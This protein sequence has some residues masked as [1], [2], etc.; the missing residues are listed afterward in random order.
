MENVIFI[1]LKIILKFSKNDNFKLWIF[2]NENKINN[3]LIFHSILK[4]VI[5]SWN[6]I[7]RFF[8]VGTKRLEL[9]ENMVD[10]VKKTN[11]HIYQDNNESTE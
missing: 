7:L 3:Y 5:G 10:K 9:K 8:F 4:F 11:D 6:K 2:C 1:L